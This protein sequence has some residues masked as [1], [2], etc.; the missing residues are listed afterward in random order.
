MT[1]Q[2]AAPVPHCSTFV[3]PNLV[4]SFNQFNKSVLLSGNDAIF[5]HHVPLFMSASL[6]GE[7][8]RWIR[9]KTL[10]SITFCLLKIKDLW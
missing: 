10:L 9:A 7:R 5:Y 6:W 1:W 4:T 8:G 3:I 2:R